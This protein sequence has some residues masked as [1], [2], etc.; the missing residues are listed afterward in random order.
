[1]RR[2][3]SCPLTVGARLRKNHRV[4]IERMK[5]E[6]RSTSQKETILRPVAYPAID[7]IRFYAALAIFIQHT[8][9]GLFLE[10]L[11]IPAKDLSYQSDSML[12]R[13]LYYVQ[14]GNHGVDVFFIISGFLM[15]RIVLEDSRPFNYFTFIRNRFWRI[16]PAFLVALCIT[17]ASVCLIFGWPWKSL[18]FAKNLVFMNA[19][20]GYPV[21]PYLHVSWSLGFEFAFYLFVPT[22]YLFS[23]WIDK[24]LVALFL[25]I[26]A[27]A[28]IPDD[29]I[30]MKALFVGTLLGAFSNQHLS[31]I[32]RSTPMLVA[33]GLYVGCGILKAVWFS[34]FI[35]YYYAFLPIAALLFVKIVWDDRSLLNKLFS[36]TSLRWLG[37]LSYSIYLYHTIV[38]SIVLNRMMP[39]NPSFFSVL[40]YLCASFALTVG[41]AYASYV[42]IENR[43]FSSKKASPPRPL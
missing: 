4:N 14:D 43:Y 16:Y 5:K 29:Y 6:K 18:D 39:S 32:A 3:D 37:T 22:L 9:G 19:I 23:R 38:G 42:L 1:M 21:L 10:Y 2:G 27:V 30:R 8:L 34:S 31:W 28:L 7:G 24:R 36:A 17:V 35:S 40:W 11:R 26:G 41:M 33:V 13:W 15:A 25:L 20:P 12:L